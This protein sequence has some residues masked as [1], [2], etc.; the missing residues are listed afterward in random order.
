[1]ICSR[2]AKVEKMPLINR[3][4]S[5]GLLFSKSEDKELKR[6][7]AIL[8]S[9]SDFLDRDL[10]EAW[11]ILAEDY[12]WRK[13]GKQ[14]EQAYLECLMII[15]AIGDQALLSECYSDLG[16]SLYFCKNYE[17][18]LHYYQKAIEIVKALSQIEMLVQ[19]YNGSASCC[20]DLGFRDQERA[21]LGECLKLSIDALIK[22]TFLERMALSY[23]ST[24]LYDEAVTY[25][26][27]ALSIFESNNFRRSWEDRIDSL[28]QIYT[29]KGD[30]AAARRT[31]ERRKW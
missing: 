20:A 16:N 18:A 8:Q 5:M 13:E 24:G 15:Q 9:K 21:Y 22:A 11:A 12:K 31:Y 23:R 29:A 10:I 7:R 14:C 25:H 1:M 6:A 17:R 4:I 26:E 28:V 3:E 27:E 19:L 2:K 30:A